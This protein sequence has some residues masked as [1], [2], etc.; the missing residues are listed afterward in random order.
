VG[1]VGP[2]PRRAAATAGAVNDNRCAMTNTKWVIDGA[3]VKDTFG[4]K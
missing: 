3:L 2:I 4:F 1:F